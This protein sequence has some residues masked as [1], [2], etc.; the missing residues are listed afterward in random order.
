MA[1]YHRPRDFMPK[2][3][4]GVLTN[5]LSHIRREIVIVSIMVVCAGVA[6]FV[7]S[8]S[9]SEDPAPLKVERVRLSEAVLREWSGR[10]ERIG[11][12]RERGSIE[13]GTNTL[14]GFVEWG[15]KNPSELAKVME[16]DQVV[17]FLGVVQALGNARTRLRQLVEYEM[18][19]EEEERLASL[20]ES[21]VEVAYAEPPNLERWEEDDLSVYEA[22]IDRVEEVLLKML[23]GIRGPVPAWEQEVVENPGE[24]GVRRVVPKSYNMRMVNRSRYGPKVV[25]PK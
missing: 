17:R 23:P 9:P 5:F 14:S 21:G 7:A 22:D 3:M 20:V 13:I 18:R 11:G 19:A 24:Q 2:S 8:A 4:F 16:E 10:A 25:R 6:Y 12:L 1:R 15:R